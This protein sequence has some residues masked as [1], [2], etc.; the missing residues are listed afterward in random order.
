[1]NILQIL[2][3]LNYGGVET[4]TVDLAKYL[5]KAQ[6]KAVVVSAGGELVDKLKCLGAVHYSLAVNKKSLFSI[7]RA[8]FELVKIIQREDIRV[9][10]ARSRVPAWSAY[11]AA[12][13]TNV[14][15]ITTCHG[16]YSRHILSRVMGWGKL[17]IVPSQIIGRRMIDDFAVSPERIRLI[18][19]GVDAENFTFILP[20]EKSR[21]E[22]V[23]A[24]IARI[25]PIKG[26]L[27]FIKAIQR[28][29]RSIP[30]IKVWIIGTAPKSK[31]HYKEDLEIL[32]KRL[33]LAHIVEFLGKRNDIPQLFSKINLLVMASTTHE[34]F[35]R[36][37]VEAQI[38]GVPVVATRVGGVVDIVEDGV[39]GLLC[40]PKDSE[41]MAEAIIRILRDN[42]LSSL[43]AKNGHLKALSKFNLEKMAKDTLEV[44]QEAVGFKRILIIKLSALGDLILS[45]PALKAIRKK[46]HS[47]HKITLLTGKAIAAVVS[48]CPYLDEVMVYDFNESDKGIFK[49]F[50]LGKELRRKNFDMV[51]DLQNNRKSHILCALSLASLRCGYQNKK[52]SFLLNRKVKEDK[53]ILGPLEHQFRVLNL[54]DIE[55]KDR[56]IELWPSKE[57]E[58]YIDDFLNSEWL[59]GSQILVGVHLSS[60]QKWLTKRWPLEYAAHLVEELALRDIRVVLTGE[61]MPQNELRVFNEMAK[62]SK[63]IIACGKTTINQL[64][65]LI[66]R[67]NVFISG[68]TAP[69]HIASGI[70]TPV[71]ALFGPTDPRRH[72]SSEKD[73]LI[74]KKDLECQPCYKPKC[75]SIE[76]MKKISVDEVKEAVLKLL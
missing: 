34:A 47:P 52:F 22:F 3:E 45:I 15:F 69:L 66:K 23:I 70:G 44:Y 5:V 14:P 13:L 21:T 46:Y 16:Y 4:G 11:F 27:Y 32:V 8:C 51:V 29:Y 64:A 20:E 6:H 54:L 17:V 10:H 73:A 35:G 65:C 76:C 48:N 75:V 74:L 61:R 36:V 7:V 56:K 55:L 68:D 37:I 9:V 43:L 49:L 18:P 60:S 2:P 53:F 59:S 71:I 26:H 50:H 63:P 1:M 39:D 38:S 57:D 41:G 67:C 12:K 40:V 25:T 42:E 24:F 30:N 31:F 28:V 72:I 33:G 19:R 58:R 62:K